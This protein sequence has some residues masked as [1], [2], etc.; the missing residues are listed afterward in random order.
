VT[1][2][3]EQELR[4]KKRNARCTEASEKH[5]THGV[6]RP[7]AKSR[8]VRQLIMRGPRATRT[9]PSWLNDRRFGHSRLAARQVDDDAA[10]VEILAV[11]VGDG[12]LRL[13]GV[14]ED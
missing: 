2:G 5:Q 12:I 7:E 13:S 8:Y 6:S 11:E 14:I 3:K 4:S 9:Y 10:S 1:R